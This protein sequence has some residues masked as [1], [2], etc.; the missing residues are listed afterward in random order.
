[1]TRGGWTLI[2]SKCTTASTV[3]VPQFY[4]SWNDFK[5]GFGDLNCTHWIGNDFINYLTSLKTMQYRVDVWNTA[6]DA[7]YVIRS[8]IYVDVEANYY[9]LTLGGVT[10]TSMPGVGTGANGMYFTTYDSDN[11]VWSG[12]FADNIYWQ[13]V[14]WFSSCYSDC[15]TCQNLPQTLYNPGNI[16]DGTQWL[17]FNYFEMK[18]Y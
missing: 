7:Q 5:I 1:M 16:H 3:G 10:S 8:Q 4:K 12:N 15:I 11:D 6:Y 13:G 14:W 9:R 17:F 2:A 18:V